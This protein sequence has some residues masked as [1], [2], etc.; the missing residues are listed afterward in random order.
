ML[1]KTAREMAHGIAEHGK[2][3]I[4]NEPVASRLLSALVLGWDALPLEIQIRLLRDASLM[5][6][7]FPNTTM[8]P[9][10]ILAFIERH[11]EGPS[12]FQA[13]SKVI[14]ESGSSPCR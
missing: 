5:D 11:K 6:H 8:L 1:R 13:L 2:G 3:A 4:A 9:K 14:T 7:G 10:T 12:P